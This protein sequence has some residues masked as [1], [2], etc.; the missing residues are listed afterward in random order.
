MQGKTWN[1]H[2]K[3]SDQTGFSSCCT[4]TIDVFSGWTSLDL[5]THFE[6]KTSH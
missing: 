5:S 4:V 6:N 3:G 2:D 1:S